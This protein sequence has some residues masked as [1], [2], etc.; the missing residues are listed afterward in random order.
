MALG[1]NSG[2]SKDRR[3]GSVKGEEGLG[4]A[5]CTRALG[6]KRVA[7]RDDMDFDSISIRGLKKVRSEYFDK[8]SL[9]ESLPQDV[10]IRVLCGVRHDDLK[11]LF[12]VSKTIR[13]A[14]LIAKQWH[15][16]YRTP[17][18]VLA[19]KTNIDG[20]RCEEIDKIEVPNAP[21]H[22]KCA[23]PRLGQKELADISVALFSSLDRLG[24]DD[25]WLRGGPV[26]N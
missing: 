8:S 3:A 24:D 13:E 21:K 5:M 16:A 19:V 2:D 11:H 4:F 25:Q 15:F 17:S 20:E 12:H 7:L 1:K 23:R 18:K 6:R 9:L 22:S 14:A 26:P 10:L